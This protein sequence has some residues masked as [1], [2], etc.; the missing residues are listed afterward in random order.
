[1]NNP[2]LVDTRHEFVEDASGQQVSVYKTAIK[3]ARTGLA[4]QHPAPL[5]PAQ[6]LDIADQLRE[7][8]GVLVRGA[9]ELA[10]ETPARDVLLGAIEHL[11]VAGADVT[12][13]EGA[14][15]LINFYVEFREGVAEYLLR[16]SPPR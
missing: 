11:R 16:S 15:D 7:L 12:T 13:L 2:R 10:W 6:A 5:T 9:N 8:V 4:V 1:M 14:Q 3:G